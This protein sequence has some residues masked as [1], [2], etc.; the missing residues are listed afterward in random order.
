M[1]VVISRNC[2]SQANLLNIL[3]HPM[4][5]S[6]FKFRYNYGN[7]P[8]ITIEHIMLK[9]SE[10]D[11][12]LGRMFAIADEDSLYLLEFTDRLALPGE[13]ER[14]KKRTKSEITP[15][16]TRQIESIAG[17]LKRYFDGTLKIFQ[18]PLFMLG[19]DFQKMAWKA[20]LDIPYGETRSYAD[21]AAAIGRPSS[22]RAAANANGANQ[23]AIV[24]PCH[25][26]INSDGKLGGYGGG[27]QRKQWLLDHEKL[28][29]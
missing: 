26:I 19:S 20:L 12:P 5:L 10:L 16:T 13:I 22:Y 27:L 2:N 14:L 25:R 23:I 29:S 4:L 3:L 15:G 11:T 17:E 7:I 21:Q 9:S 1:T 8:Q 18:T 28:Y 24:I 6:D